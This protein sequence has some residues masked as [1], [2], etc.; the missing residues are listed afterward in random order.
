MRWFPTVGKQVSVFIDW[1]VRWPC[2]T[3]VDDVAE[4]VEDVDAA[5]VTG[6]R[7]RVVQCGSLG[8]GVGA[9]CQPAAGQGYVTVDALDIVVVEFIGGRGKDTRYF[10]P[11]PSR[12]FGGGKQRVIG[13]NADT[14]F[15]VHQPHVDFLEHHF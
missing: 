12:M 10:V 9:D 3:S 13:W 11:L 14:G 1:S 2:G 4:V 15:D 7:K 8:S 6:D 5:A